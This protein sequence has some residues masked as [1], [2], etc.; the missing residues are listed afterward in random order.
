MI[1]KPAAPWPLSN[2]I[3]SLFPR[4]MAPFLS[5]RTSVCSSADEWVCQT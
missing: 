2:A 3:N 5:T 1:E 4:R